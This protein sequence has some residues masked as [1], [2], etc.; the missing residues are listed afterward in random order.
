M[1]TWGWST[2]KYRRGRG[3]GYIKAIYAT[4]GGVDRT[5][6]V[7]TRNR[8]VKA[9]QPVG[10]FLTKE[11]KQYDAHSQSEMADGLRIVSFHFKFNGYASNEN[12]Y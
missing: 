7:R 4:Y 2:L 6:L 8:R 5:G 10:S 1:G 12:S 9:C 11:L 3:G